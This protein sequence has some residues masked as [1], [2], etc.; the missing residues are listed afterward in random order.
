[1]SNL[2]PLLRLQK[3]KCGEHKACLASC[4]LCWALQEARRA[5]RIP[6][7]QGPAPLVAFLAANSSGGA[8]SYMVHG[9]SPLSWIKSLSALRV[10]CRELSCSLWP[11]PNETRDARARESFPGVEPEKGWRGAMVQ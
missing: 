5:M 7:S 10:E 9:Q 3:K 2:R 8:G 1:M 6:Y 4:L 11:L